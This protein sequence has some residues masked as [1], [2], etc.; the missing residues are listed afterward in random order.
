MT[1]HDFFVGHL[2]RQESTGNTSWSGN[3]SNSLVRRQS[4]CPIGLWPRA[5][6]VSAPSP[7]LQHIPDMPPLQSAYSAIH[8]QAASV[9]ARATA[10]IG[11]CGAVPSYVDSLGS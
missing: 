8:H 11:R 9:F 4:D 10:L 7:Y 2:G 5:P 6:W 1:L 3:T